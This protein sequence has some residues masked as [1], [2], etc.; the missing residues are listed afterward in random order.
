M[1]NETNDIQAVER[2]G[3]ARDALLEGDL[4]GYRK[5][6]EPVVA[7]LGHLKT[8]HAAGAV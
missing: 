3:E 1:T 5:R 4:R 2:L 8:R 7:R 6:V